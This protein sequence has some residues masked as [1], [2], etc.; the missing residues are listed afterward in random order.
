MQLY[1]NHNFTLVYV[2]SIA[3]QEYVAYTS[4]SNQYKVSH[5]SNT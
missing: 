5:E 3:N 1:D 2:F 4:L